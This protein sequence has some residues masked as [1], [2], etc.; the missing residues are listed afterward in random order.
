MPENGAP[1]PNGPLHRKSAGQALDDVN[2]LSIWERMRS[3][4]KKAE[5]ARA[6]EDKHKA[7]ASFD[8]YIREKIRE[9]EILRKKIQ[10]KERIAELQTRLAELEPRLL[11]QIE[12]TKAAKKRHANRVDNLT[13]ERED[14]GRR[15]RQ[16]LDE[17]WGADFDPQVLEDLAIAMSEEAA[18]PIDEESLFWNGVDPDQSI[19]SAA[20]SR[21]GGRDLETTQDVEEQRRTAIGAG[22]QTANP[23]P[24]GHGPGPQPQPQPEQEDK[25]K[26]MEGVIETGSATNGYSHM[27]GTTSGNPSES[28]DDAPNSILYNG[29]PGGTPS[30]T[31]NGIT[32]NTTDRTADRIT[33]NTHKAINRGA[34]GTEDGTADSSGANNH[35]SSVYLTKSHLTNGKLTNGTENG[36]HSAGGTPSDQSERD[37]SQPDVLDDSGTDELGR[38]P[39]QTRSRKTSSRT[40][41]KSRGRSLGDRGTVRRLT[42]SRSEGRGRSRSPQRSQSRGRRRSRARSESRTTRGLSS[43]A[44]KLTLT[45]I[46]PAAPGPDEKGIVEVWSSSGS[47][48]AYVRKDVSE[49]E[50]QPQESELQAILRAAPVR[51]RVMI[52]RARIITPEMLACIDS[53]TNTKWI[54]IIK[55]ATGIV[56]SVPCSNCA[57]EAGP[58][59]AC[60]IL[61][62]DRRRKCGN[63]EWQKIKCSGA[64]ITMGKPGKPKKS[65]PA[66]TGCD[67]SGESAFLLTS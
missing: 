1:P 17:N 14:S 63:C 6:V 9:L 30:G 48:I 10:I 64:S 50:P 60:T 43:K 21:P 27:N 19:L 58:F 57:K 38:K 26:P 28:P 44:H 45:I 34:S 23:L 40:R 11:K 61:L 32:N 53:T 51:H 55:Q 4:L 18:R 16:W 13:K 56:H 7:N 46:P 39:R 62:D 65:T 20:S 5:E 31:S 66:S 47:L 35:L 15:S 54:S 12:K 36:G 37:V 29:T 41:S 8:E 49:P 2:L 22:K 25:S 59:Q 24:N 67:G 52:R 3:N 42:R 33:N